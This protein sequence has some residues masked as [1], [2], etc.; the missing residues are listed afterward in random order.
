[1]N[2][3]AARWRRIAAGVLAGIAATLGVSCSSPAAAPIAIH[4]DHLVALLDTPLS[5]TVSGLPADA[6]VTVDASAVDCDG[7]RY[8][9]QATFTADNNG[10]LDLDTAA[11]TGGSYT[12]AGAM[13]LIENMRPT[14]G[15]Q[16]EFVFCTPQSGFA[17]KLSAVAAGRAAA[18]VTVRRLWLLPGVTEHD[19]RPSTDGFYG[20]F[21]SPAPGVGVRPGVLELGGSEGGLTV[22]DEAAALASHGYPTLALA[23]FGEP[24]IPATEQDI[25]LEYFAKALRWLAAQRGVD[26]N[27]VVVDGASRGG[28]GALLLGAYYPSLVHAVIAQTTSSVVE[29]GF[30]ANDQCAG[31][32]WTLRGVGLPYS[33]DFKYPQPP[34]HPDEVIPVEKIDGP[35]LLDCGGQDVLIPSCPFGMTIEDR[36]NSMHFRFSHQFV[37][38]QDAGHWVNSG[39]P[40]RPV[41]DIYLGGTLEANQRGVADFWS[42][43]LTF[44]ASL[45]G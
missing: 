18:H 6:Q 21:F 42:R 15:N 3:A 35:I 37:T 23:Y 12:A 38:Y 44:L 28:E 20:E 9:S 39:I 10:R 13:G 30:D 24:G 26:R 32:A 2:E 22:A 19:L 45:G 36:L 5:I 4:V 41:F 11:P 43:Q 1:M 14:T 27:R 33:T 16:S 25:P 29:C 7:V 34:G 8:L 40:Y 31:A 17:I